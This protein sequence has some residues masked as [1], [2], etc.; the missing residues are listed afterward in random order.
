MTGAVPIRIALVYPSDHGRSVDRDRV[1]AIA[2]SI[3]EIGLRTP[4]TVRPTTKVAD[5]QEIEAFEI[6][7]GR[8]RY[9]AACKLGMD[10]IDA[11]VSDDDDL[12]AELW[13]IDENLCRAE[14]TAADRADYIARR[15]GIYE[16]LHP[17]TKHGGDRKG[18]QVANSATRSFADD[19]AAKTGASA[20]TVRQDA[21]RGEKI[22]PDVLKEIRG[23]RWDKGTTLDVLKRLTHP[24]QRQALFRVKNGA[25][26]TFDAAFD[27]IRGEAA[28]PQRKP[29]QPP[30]RALNDMEVFNQQ[31]AR[32]V[33]A[34]NGAS[35]EA[36]QA[37]VEQCV[38][39]PVMDRSA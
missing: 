22:A 17:E 37:F 34:W 21:E 13:E 2:D 1:A 28:A 30:G 3:K 5:G 14:L 23:T 39:T 20:R 4:I 6:V 18:D 24:E 11:I 7:A 33:S 26:A 15:K 16:A 19:T 32:L 25:D 38:D 12:H 10:E 35:R 27:F 8:H 31:L 9:E 29:V 36:R